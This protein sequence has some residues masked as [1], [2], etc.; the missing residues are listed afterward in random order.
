M[1][2]VSR[3]GDLIPLSPIN[4]REFT[5]REYFVEPNTVL[6][7]FGRKPLVP[8]AEIQEE[9]LVF[10]FREGSEYTFD[11]SQIGITENEFTAVIR[12][13]FDIRI[14][15][16]VEN[17]AIDSQVFKAKIIFYIGKTN[18]VFDDAKYALELKDAWIRLDT[19][20]IFSHVAIEEIV[21]EQQ[22]IYPKA[23]PAF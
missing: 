9:K 20:R 17:R 12:F 2:Y 19:P 4:N 13:R 15:G 8:I 23:N 7:C 22:E 21:N 11:I 6:P 16:M 1:N 10:L 18:L 5:R 3:N 14:D